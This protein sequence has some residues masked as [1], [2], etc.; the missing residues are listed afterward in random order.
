MKNKN[1]RCSTV[2]QNGRE[3]R[4]LAVTGTDPA[5][6]PAH[7]RWRARTG[8]YALNKHLGEGWFPGSTV[9]PGHSAGLAKR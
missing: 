1:K 5:L 9:E 8:A 7:R 4:D 3:C 2:L 6:C